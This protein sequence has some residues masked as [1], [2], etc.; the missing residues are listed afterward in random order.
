[1]KIAQRLLNNI[2][3]LARSVLPSRDNG[4]ADLVAVAKQVRRCPEIA[5]WHDFDK[6][7]A[8]KYVAEH[9][10][11]LAAARAALQRPCRIE[12]RMVKEFYEEHWPETQ[13]LR[14]LATLFCTEA[15]LANTQQDLPRLIRA[16]IDLLRL[17]NATR[18]GGMIL[19]ALVAQSASGMGIDLLR[20]QRA[21]FNDEQR[22]TL[23]EALLRIE[24][25]AESIEAIIT[26]DREWENV[27]NH[28]ATENHD[29]IPMDPEEIG[30]SIAD[31]QEFHD[32][33]RASVEHEARLPPDQQRQ[34]ERGI[35]YTGQALLR[36]LITDLALRRFQT[37]QGLLPERLQLLVPEFLPALPLDPFTNTP[38]I[39]RPHGETFELYSTGPKQI[40]G[41]GLFTS[42]SM[43]S[44][45]QGDLCLDVHDISDPENVCEIAAEN[46]SRSA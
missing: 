5:P 18:N 33:I 15:R 31:Q 13:S 14:Q 34:K 43:V 21:N 22:Q 44:M 16:G 24:P 1:M 19:D 28:A 11:Q 6:E 29:F 41:G 20:R 8:E 35:E 4:Y 37:A 27:T 23:I 10:E 45:H 42:R 9:A 26:R 38:L 12:M 17:G 30:I 39:Y 2:T 32:L 40:D 25:A 7:L 46:I 3:S 36:M